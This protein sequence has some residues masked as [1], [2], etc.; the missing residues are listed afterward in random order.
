MVR[1]TFQS[2]RP[3]PFLERLGDS[4]DNSEP[5]EIFKPMD[6]DKAAAMFAKAYEQLFGKDN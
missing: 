6:V 1:G 2:S 5:D 4:A 3:S